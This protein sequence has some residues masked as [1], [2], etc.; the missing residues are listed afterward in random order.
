MLPKSDIFF[1][2]FFS[3][4]PKETA[5]SFTDEQLTAVKMAFGGRTWGAHAIDLRRSLPLFGYRFYMVLLC[6]REQR[7]S[8]R[9]R[10]INGE[11]PVVRLGNA[12]ILM[13]FFAFLLLAL[14]GVLYGIKTM[15]DI[16]VIPG[17]DVLPDEAIRSIFN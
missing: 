16:D 15:F 10:A 4:I 8:D 5:A 11:H 3:R 2:K 9:I 13:L 14:L 17:I 1:E 7:S 6:G 12:I